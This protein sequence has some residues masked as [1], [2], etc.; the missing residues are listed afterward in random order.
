MPVTH[1]AGTLWDPRGH[2][3][4][5]C[6]DLAGSNGTLLGGEEEEKQQQEQDFSVPPALATAESRLRAHTASRRDHVTDTEHDFPVGGDG[7][8]GLTT[9]KPPI[10]RIEEKVKV[11]L[12]A[13][14]EYVTIVEEKDT[15]QE[16][17]DATR[18][19]MQ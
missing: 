6:R 19:I 12:H 16:N 17:A 3:Y 9:P 7:Q 5:C 13:M 15:P 10:A 1:A 4:T 18:E 2:N 11:H 14:T 8:A